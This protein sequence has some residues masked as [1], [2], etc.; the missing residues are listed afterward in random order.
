MAESGTTPEG[1]RQKGLPAAVAAA[2]LCFFALFVHSGFPLVLLSASGLVAAAVAIH[3]SLR[4]DASP[5]RT[6]GLGRPSRS[7]V[8]WTLVGC[9]LGV[10]LGLA[11]R[12][13]Y[14]ADLL[15]GRLAP[16][17]LVAVLIGSTEELIY[18]GYLQGTWRRLGPA[19]AAVGAAAAHTAYKCSLF[20]LRPEGVE[21]SLGVLA[22]LT[23]LGGLAFGALRERSGSVLPPLAAH[24]WFEIVVYGGLS[25]APWWVWA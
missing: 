12:F 14:A 7:V 8:L 23:F 4:A 13:R 5:A 22:A 21:V 9:A 16:F 11:H 3:L 2:G 6:W 17:A 24:A 1:R 20:V 10:A 19:W 15:P 18:R 25:S